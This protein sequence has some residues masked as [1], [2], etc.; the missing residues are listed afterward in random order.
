MDAEGLITY[1]I[2]FVIGAADR[3]VHVVDGDTT[4]EVWMLQ[5][6]REVLD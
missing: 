5:M 1:Y 4:S 2:V 3:V 6:A